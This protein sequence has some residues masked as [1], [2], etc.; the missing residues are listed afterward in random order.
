M[1]FLVIRLSLTPLAVLAGTVA[2]RRFGH[3]ISGLVLGLPL[4]SLPILWFIA[5]R[6]GAPFA[7]TMTAA[8]LVGS[9]AEAAVLW[10]YAHLTA[11][12]SPTLALGG[13]LIA[14]ALFAA[15]VNLLGL[16]PIIAGLVTA[17]GFAVALRWWPAVEPVADTSTRRARVVPRVVVAALLTFMIMALAGHLGPVWSGLLD[18]LPAMSMMMAFM[19][20]QDSG[21]AASSSFLRGVTRG[22]FSYVAAMLV[23]AETLRTGDLP[24][25]FGAALGASLVVQALVQL[26]DTLALRSLGSVERRDAMCCV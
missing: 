19:T 5:V 1:I 8:L 21:A 25:A 22:S 10:L 2:Q 15:A 13:A 14:F 4:T 11:R 18:A 23:L 20:H 24:L 7:E 17:V 26:R 12:V 6:H 16:S 9:V 3:A